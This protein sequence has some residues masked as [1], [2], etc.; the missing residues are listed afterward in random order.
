MTEYAPTVFVVDDDAT[1]RAAVA[2]LLKAAGFRAE[3]VASA[4][5]FF[6]RPLPDSPTCAVVD[7]HVPGLDG[8][9]PQQILAGRDLPVVLVTSNGDVPTAVRAMKAGAVDFLTKPFDERALLDAVRRA[10]DRAAETRRAG[11]ERADAR[12]R[13]GALTPRER[14]VMDLVV[15][16][17]L[18][19]QVAQ[20][21]G[22]AEKT[23][24][25]HRARVMGKMGAGSLVELARMAGQ[26]NGAGLPAG[27]T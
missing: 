10:L 18:N 26:L 25:V 7:L 2:R 6:A 27:K 21:L 24:K 11:A 8:L 17:M 14:E 20:E 13:A 4:E 15:T 12:R 22:I 5:E 16:G 9:D 19:K 23:V 3:V 1:V